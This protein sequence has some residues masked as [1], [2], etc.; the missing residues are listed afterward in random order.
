MNK[1]KNRLT[2]KTRLLIYEYKERYPVLSAEDIADMFNLSK[3]YVEHMFKKG[4]L[5]VP[6]KM[7]S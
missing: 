7:N 4:E 1:G 2:N 3:V 5:I 6:S